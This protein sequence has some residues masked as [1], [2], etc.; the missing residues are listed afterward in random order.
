M[1]K[2][3]KLL[4]TLSFLVVALLSFAQ[5]PTQ[6]TINSSPAQVRNAFNNN[7]N[8][9]Y[10]NKA[11]KTN[12][13][14]IGIIKISN[15]TS[16]T[17]T[18]ATQ[19]YSRAHGSGTGGSM[20]YPGA[21]IP[22]SN[23]TSWG[24][25]ITNS[26]GN[27]NTAYTDRYKWDGGN[28]GLTP[29]T[30]RTSL[31]GTT[32]GSAFFTLTNPG[33]VTFPRINA[34]NTVT[35]LSAAN[36]K[37]ALGI[38]DGSDASVRAIV[39]DSLNA[40]RSGASQVSTVAIML[41]DSIGGSGKDLYAGKQY[42][43]DHGGTGASWM[44]S[45]SVLSGNPTNGNVYIHSGDKRI[46]YKVGNYWHRLQV[47]DST[48][49]EDDASTLL[50]GLVAGY[51]FDETSGVL[52]DVLGLHNGTAVA[53]PTYDASGKIGRCLTLAGGS[54]ISMGSNAA[55]KPTTALTVA[56]WF[57]T[58]TAD[59]QAIVTNYSFSVN[60]YGFTL[61]TEASSGWKLLA[62]V[63][64][65]TNWATALSTSNV[66]T[67]A[68]VH[69]VMTSDGTNLK[70]YINGAQQGTN[71]PYAHSVGYLAG[72]EFQV[73]MRDFDG[74]PLAGS[75]DMVWLYNR[76]LTSTE[77]TELYTKENTGTTYPW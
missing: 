45:L 39:A 44:D 16:V 13:V 57:K 40:L 62:G 22:V 20:T 60:S 37:T 15:G 17:D 7:F 76:A 72:S 25:S 21:G 28:S 27:W 68:W 46:H 10:A 77:I 36:M 55:L 52:Y 70:L 61:T 6:W 66:N 5:S 42:V 12:S 54:Y 43:Q 48:L 50:N 69:A 26:S 59:Y 32:I 63:Q 58:T 75:V 4:F 41:N 14:V 33:A 1:Q 11:D 65:G 9:V 29:A 34:D 51:K 56:V 3:K 24:T 53:A 31:G 47:Q 71:H 19:A 74:I 35:A 2:M 73:G 64:D 8:Y 23:G 38:V 49:I 67:G 18:L 30:G